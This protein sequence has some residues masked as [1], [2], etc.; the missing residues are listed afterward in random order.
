M[1]DPLRASIQENIQDLEEL[2]DLIIDS[3]LDFNFEQEQ[4]SFQIE[5]LVFELKESIQR[6][7][8]LSELED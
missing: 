8:K 3:G 6:A 4:I 2:R 5:G 1:T 7:I